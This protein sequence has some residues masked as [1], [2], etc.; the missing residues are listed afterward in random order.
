MAPATRAVVLMTISD[1][2]ARAR[3]LASPSVGLSSALAAIGA[4]VR[5][6]RATKR[7][8]RQAFID[9]PLASMPVFPPQLIYQP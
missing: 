4:S 2:P 5:Q 3:M 1:A 8:I 6:T 7:G 9:S